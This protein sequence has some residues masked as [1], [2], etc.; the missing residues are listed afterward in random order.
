MYLGPFYFQKRDL[1]IIIAV[2]LLWWAI[3][4]H[5]TI[6]LFNS[7][8]LLTLAI[9]FLLVKASI[10]PAHDVAVFI[11]F[12]TAII[13][14]LFMPLFQVVLFLAC[15]FFLQKLLKVY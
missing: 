13:L 9:I 12:F 7:Y 4:S 8:N 15:A 3:Y 11:T 2:A 10:L 5:M 1:F 6:P 14:T